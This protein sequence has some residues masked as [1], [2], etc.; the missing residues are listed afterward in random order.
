MKCALLNVICHVQLSAWEWWSGVGFL[1]KSLIILGL[2][3]L[4]LGVSW[5]FL[6]LLK[7]VGGWPAVIGFAVLVLGIVLALMPHKPKGDYPSEVDGPD[8]APPISRPKKRSLGAPVP[9]D[10]RPGTWNFREGRWN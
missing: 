5:S 4:I 9:P 3:A 2:V 8:A 7:A 10:N 6:R 1:N